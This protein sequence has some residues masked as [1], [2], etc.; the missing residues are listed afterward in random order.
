M[1]LYNRNWGFT[2]FEQDFL[3][4]NTKHEQSDVS[5]LLDHSMD[6]FSK[7]N[8]AL[9]GAS[10]APMVVMSG[11]HSFTPCLDS[12]HHLEGHDIVVTLEFTTL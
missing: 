2:S 8:K 10:M 9:H 4:W 12:N 1:E 6:K 7:D 3:V 11:S 5:E